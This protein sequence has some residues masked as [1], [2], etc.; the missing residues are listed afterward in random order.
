MERARANTALG[1]LRQLRDSEGRLNPSMGKASQQAIAKAMLKVAPYLER[2]RLKGDGPAPEQTPAPAPQAQAPAPKQGVRLDGPG[3]D[4]DD[5][6]YADGGIQYRPDQRATRQDALRI[7]STGFK[8][9]LDTLVSLTETAMEK[10]HGLT[11]QQSRDLQDFHDKLTSAQGMHKIGYYQ[12]RDDFTG[13]AN[14]L[15]LSAGTKSDVAHILK[16]A[17]K[18]HGAIKTYEPPVSKRPEDMT[19]DEYADMRFNARSP[20]LEKDLHE[21]RHRLAAAE[22][23]DHAH[24]AAVYGRSLEKL[25]QEKAARDADPEAIKEGHREE[26]RHMTAMFAANPVDYNTE[27]EAPSS[28]EGERLE[29]QAARDQK[30]GRPVSTRT[31]EELHM[32]RDQLKATQHAHVTMTGKPYRPNARELHPML[33]NATAKSQASL[34]TYLA[35]MAGGRR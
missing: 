8:G 15:H 9:Q 11:P 1:V 29:R 16:Q 20:E 25:E 3:P 19:P 27:E 32:V 22:L 6:V 5:K 34:H 30:A 14:L 26:H 12:Q 21:T 24:N 17:E 10:I 33:G 2:Q 13:R 18:L 35:T 7:G 23:E 31:K 4:P 28:D